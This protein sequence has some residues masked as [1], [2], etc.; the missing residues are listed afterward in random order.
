M[1]SPEIESVH[2]CFEIAG[3]FNVQ[4]KVAYGDLHVLKSQRH[5]IDGKINFSVIFYHLPCKAPV[6]LIKINHFHFL[7]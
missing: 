1:V 4:F 5:K 7:K 2:N 6:T 3:V